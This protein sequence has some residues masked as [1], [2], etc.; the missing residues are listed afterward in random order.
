M[1]GGPQM[2]RGMGTPSGRYWDRL[3]P[4]VLL[5]LYDGH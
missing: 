1:D 3:T 4:L 2:L 5:P